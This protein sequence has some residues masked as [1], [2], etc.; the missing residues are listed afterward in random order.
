MFAIDVKRRLAGNDDLK[1]RACGEQLRHYRRRRNEVLEQLRD[2]AAE[3]SML[4]RSVDDLETTEWSLRD[5][6]L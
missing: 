1:P 4:D 2:L 3:L 5:E 6:L